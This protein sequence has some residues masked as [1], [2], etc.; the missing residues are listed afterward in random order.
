HLVSR[1]EELNVLVYESSRYHA[2]SFRRNSS[3]AASSS[4]I[5]S[6]AMRNTSDLTS[7]LR[8]H[9]RTHVALN[10]PFSATLVAQ[11]WPKSSLSLASITLFVLCFR[12][13]FVVALIVFCY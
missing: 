6:R 5:S 1:V 4:S 10:P 12:R 3:L 8:K 2:P 7:L 13:F 11:A 9:S